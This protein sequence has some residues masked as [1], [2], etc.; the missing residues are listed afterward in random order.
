MPIIT[1]NDII[2]A[3]EV[4]SAAISLN[5]ID[6]YIKLMITKTNKPV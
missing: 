1:P 5:S 6:N 4:K 2:T 3:T